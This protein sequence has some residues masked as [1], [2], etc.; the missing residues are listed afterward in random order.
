[1]RCDAAA[2]NAILLLGVGVAVE[3]GERVEVLLL[4]PPEGRA[5]KRAGD[6]WGPRFRSVRPG[7]Q[8]Q[9]ACAASIA[10]IQASSKGTT[11]MTVVSSKKGA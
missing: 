8:P 6:D 11:G 9:L 7:C 3:Q 2:A 10:V 1:M 4:A 5:C